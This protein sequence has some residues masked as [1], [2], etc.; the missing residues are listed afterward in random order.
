MIAVTFTFDPWAVLEWL[1][2]AVKAASAYFITRRQFQYPIWDGNGFQVIRKLNQ[3]CRSIMWNFIWN[4]EW[5]AVKL[6]AFIPVW[7]FT[8]KKYWDFFSPWKIQKTP[9]LCP[10]C[11]DKGEYTEHS[12]AFFR[13]E[14]EPERTKIILC[15]CRDHRQPAPPPQTGHTCVV[16]LDLGHIGC[17]RECPHCKHR[18]YLERKHLEQ[19]GVGSS[20]SDRNPHIRDGS[21]VRDGTCRTCGCYCNDLELA[22][23]YCRNC[24]AK[25]ILSPDAGKQ[26]YNRDY[27]GD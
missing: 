4:P 8:G 15:N 1:Y 3:K 9:P 21:V 7:L 24:Y 11:R 14:G 16:C 20:V 22:R 23:G 18:K 25:A 5:A 2:L 13:A 17:G 27:N 10:K 6:I 12:T 19:T 26:R